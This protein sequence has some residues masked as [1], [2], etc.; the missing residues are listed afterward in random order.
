M[1]IS[2]LV[3]TVSRKLAPT[4]P[5]MNAV[6]TQWLAL[7]KQD[8]LDKTEP[9][10]VKGLETAISVLKKA[11]SVPAAIAELKKMEASAK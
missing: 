6:L 9:E 1:E 2:N 8:K 5:E 4:K 11:A 10:Y 3:E 7:A